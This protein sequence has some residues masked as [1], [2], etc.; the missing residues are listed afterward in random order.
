[1]LAEKKMKT[2]N[3]SAYQATNN[4]TFNNKRPHYYGMENDRTVRHRR[5]VINRQLRSVYNRLRDFSELEAN[6]DGNGAF[7]FSAELIENVEKILNQIK[8][9][10]E[11]F[12]TGRQSIQLEFEKSNGDYLEFEVFENKVLVLKDIA[13][14]MEEQV[15]D[16][17]DILKINELLE[18]FYES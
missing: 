16:Y 3:L 4:S 13:D 14:D 17:G 1:M 2:R 11:I 12:P 9:I 5:G 7:K 15:I 6:W 18:S 8:Y 10:P